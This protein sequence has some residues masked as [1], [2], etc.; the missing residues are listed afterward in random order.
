CGL[1]KFSGRITNRSSMG[2]PLGWE[3][4]FVSH[5]H[6][7][8][9]RPNY[10]QNPWRTLLNT[11]ELFITQRNT[12]PS[13]EKYSSQSTPTRQMNGRIHSQGWVLLT[14]HFPQQKKQ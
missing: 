3:D 8:R 1:Y 13:S 11:I 12:S 7:I 14:P 6:K 4:D 10:C 2:G 5:C 9:P